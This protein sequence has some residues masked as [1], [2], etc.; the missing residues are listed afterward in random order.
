LLRPGTILPLD[1]EQDEGS[2]SPSESLFALSRAETRRGA[3]PLEP[4]RCCCLVPM[5][6]EEEDD[7]AVASAKNALPPFWE[8][9]RRRNPAPVPVPVPVFGPLCSP[10]PWVDRL[11]RLTLRFRS[12]KATA[13]GVLAALP[14]TMIPLL[15]LRCC[16]RVPVDGAEGAVLMLAALTS[17]LRLRGPPPTILLPPPAPAA[18][19]EAEAAESKLADK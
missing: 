4:C 9:D 17:T 13:V 7:E 2:P 8:A 3:E 15:F 19:E 12:P 16:A 18:T 10:P 1:L 5:T 11:S 14:P 6:P